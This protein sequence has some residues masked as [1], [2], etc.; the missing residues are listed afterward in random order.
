MEVREGRVLVPHMGSRAYF[1]DQ[2]T[3]GTYNRTQYVAWNLL[4]KTLRYTID[5]AGAGCGCNAALYLVSMRQNERPSTCDDYYCDANHVCGI[6]CAEIDIQEANLYAWHSTLHASSDHN[7]VGAGFGGGDGWNGP[8]DFTAHQYSPGGQCID[9]S[10]PF[11]VAASF[12]INSE[13][14]FQGME[15][16]LTQQGRTCPLNVKVNAYAGLAELSRALAAGMTPVISYWSSDNMLWMDG[17]GS[18]GQGPCARDSAAACTGAVKF[19][20]IS[21]SSIGAEAGAARP[22][23]KMLLGLQ[24]AG[25]GTERRGSATCP[26]S[27]E[28]RGYGRVSLVGAKWNV[29]GQPAGPVEISTNSAIVPHLKG[30]AY[31]GD[32]CVPEVYNNEHYVGLGLLGQ[33]LRYTTDMSGAGCGCN[34]ALYLVSMKQNSRAS[35][36][37]DHYCDANNVCGES[38]AEIDIQEANQYAWHSTL[39]TAQD[40]G[41]LGVGYGGGTSW[42]GPRNFDARQYGPG[43]ACIDTS[44]PFQVA[45][46]FPLSAQGILQAVEIVLSQE[47]HAC[48]LHVKLQG[49][50]GMRELSESL[51]AG[52]TPVVSYW[53][54]DDMTWMDG[55]GVDGQGP[56]SSDNAGA[57]AS[58]V[59]FYNFSVTSIE[60]YVQPNLVSLPRTP[61]TA[62]TNKILA[63]V[64][65]PG[66]FNVAGYGQ[67]WLVPTGWHND[68]AR[69]AVTPRSVLVPR[70]GGRAYFAK[71]CNAGTYDHNQYLA[72]NLLG[73]VMKYTI[74]ISGAGCGCNAAFYLVSMHQNSQP[75]SCHDYYCDA[76]N[77]C[78][79]SCAEIDIQ[80]ANQFSWHSTLHSAHDRSGKGAGF[81]GGNGW[82]GPRDFTGKQY[83]PG[84]T[85]IDTRKPFEV[86]VSFPVD[87]SGALQAMVVLLSQ[88][89]RSCPLTLRVDAYINMREL[90]QALAAG[91]TPVVSYWSSN[92][93]LWM[94]GP[95]SDGRG[96]CV[97]DVAAECVDSVKFY[98]FSISNIADSEFG[99][100]THDK[101][102][103]F[104]ASHTIRAMEATSRC[105]HV[106]EPCTS[107]PCCDTFGVKCRQVNVWYAQCELQKT[108]A[109]DQR[110]NVSQG[111]A[112]TATGAVSSGGATCPG[113]FQMKGYGAVSLIPTGWHATGAKVEVN[114]NGALI[115]HM[116]GRAY[117]ADRCTPGVYDH[118]QYL[119]LNLLGKTIRYTTDISGSGCGCNAALYLVSMRQN[120]HA[121]TCHDYYC[122]ANSVCNVS[123]AEVDIQEANQF[124]WH[125]T[126]HSSHDRSGTGGGFGGGDGWNGPRDFTSEQYSPGGSCIDTSKPFQVSASFPV[127]ALGTL[128]AMEVSLSQN[129]SPCSLAVRVNSYDNMAEL[130]QALAAGMTPVVSY[131]STDSMLWMDGAGTDGKGPCA[132]D[133]ASSCPDTA[134]FYGFSVSSIVDAVPETRSPQHQHSTIGPAAGNAT[135][136]AHVEEDCASIPCCSMPSVHCQ[137]SNGNLRCKLQATV[138]ADRGQAPAGSTLP[139][140][141]AVAASSV[142]DDIWK[143]SAAWLVMALFVVAL[144]TMPSFRRFCTSVVASMG[145]VG[146][147]V[148]S[149]LATVKGKLQAAGRKA[150][151]STVLSL[152]AS[153]EARLRPRSRS[154][155]PSA[156]A[157]DGSPSR[158]RWPS[159][160]R[161]FSPAVAPSPARWPLVR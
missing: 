86:A 31:F 49:Y 123:C 8:R 75:S 29:P 85:C 149:S 92:D 144:L 76:N 118:R 3:A 17:K 61:S 102:D 101:K 161:E 132:R 64:A 146:N 117:F 106:G 128:Q 72:L 70:M 60:N 68:G 152:A 84:G 69:V 108:A 112:E 20:D 9:T 107:T 124:A 136:C 148:S 126:L 27:F 48:P 143:Q 38:C 36:C 73:K 22:R 32:S 78:G 104:L 151:T 147:S 55:R 83:S 43:A 133:A 28:L 80:E 160:A 142:G 90:S 91:M 122:D 135:R 56:C 129:G 74:D 131:W 16:T 88:D 23:P 95:G 51:A 45:A 57:C 37:D 109:N 58:S 97:R 81:G 25:T 35:G 7:G 145:S 26:G 127:D 79:V 110:D 150:G 105:A 98:N 34:A 63:D 99:G 77:V 155:Q 89:G 119:G 116:G 100:H 46:S 153:P 59:K 14:A 137:Q 158:L 71:D 2:C 65:C 24:P 15:V 44:K 50:K 5:I 6:A 33:V 103:G 115:P 114:Q 125:S 30:R 53:S 41:G 54:A 62:P 93:M 159:G 12:P 42:N 94:D 134:K 66:S 52:M 141:T 154:L 11:E 113:R 111:H 130:S 82:D 87:A 138:I 157:L 120:S 10:R 39:H 156:E 18:D 139:V 96:P 67:V 40:H 19:Y 21:L 140:P 13:G 1:A 47:G 4:G 121:S